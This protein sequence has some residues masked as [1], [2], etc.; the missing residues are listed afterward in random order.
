MDDGQLHRTVTDGNRYDLW[1]DQS[2]SNGGISYDS[3]T[4][5]PVFSRGVNKRMRADTVV[6][7]NLKWLELEDTFEMIAG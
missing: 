7:V 6:T 1:P 3:L 2:G 5:N 4:A